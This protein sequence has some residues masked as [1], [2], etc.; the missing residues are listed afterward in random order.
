MERSTQGASMQGIIFQIELLEV[1][2]MASDKREQFRA[3]LQL[4]ID[5]TAAQL[6]AVDCGQAPEALQI[7]EQAT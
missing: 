1:T 5:G 4:I 3:A 7:C 2:K 6:N